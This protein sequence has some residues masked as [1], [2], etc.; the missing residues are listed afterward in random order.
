VVGVEGC[1]WYLRLELLWLELLWL[2]VRVVSGGKGV[3]CV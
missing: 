1:G 3:T 2:E